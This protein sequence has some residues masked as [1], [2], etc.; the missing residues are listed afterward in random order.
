MDGPRCARA[1]PAALP[2]PAAS[3]CPLHRPQSLAKC[4][5]AVRTDWCVA[6]ARRL[7]EAIQ[8]YNKSLTEH[9]NADTLKKLND[10]EKALKDK[11]EKAYIDIDKSNEEKVRA[12]RAPRWQRCR[13]RPPPGTRAP[14]WEPAPHPIGARRRGAERASVRAESGPADDTVAAMRSCSCRA[15]RLPWR[16][17]GQ[18]GVQAVGGRLINCRALLCWSCRVCLGGLQ[19]KGNLAFKEQRYPEA[20]A[21]YEEALKRG[22][23]SVNPEA[24]KLYSNLAAC[25]TKLGAYPEGVKVRQSKG[26]AWGKGAGGVSACS[27]G[28]KVRGRAGGLCGGT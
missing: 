20:V 16:R 5:A 4:V 13:W 10:T 21:A 26:W 2:P 22:P 25:Y 9:R 28:A 23:P 8:W 12:R 11:R 27:E 6:R 18:P 17:Q 19:D 7:E 1:E 15:P 3:A 14:A 24:Y